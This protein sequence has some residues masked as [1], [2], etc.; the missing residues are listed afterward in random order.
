MK[1]KSCYGKELDIYNVTINNGKVCI[2][3]TLLYDI[4]FGKEFK[5]NKECR[6][7]VWRD[8]DL[9]RTGTNHYFHDHICIFSSDNNYV[10]YIHLLDKK[11][12]MYTKESDIHFQ[13]NS[14]SIMRNAKFLEENRRKIIFSIINT[15]DEEI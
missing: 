10:G 1:F 15:L 4:T 8:P 3:N 11:A 14:G 2:N 7:A 6:F 9:F 12:V 13:R 5:N